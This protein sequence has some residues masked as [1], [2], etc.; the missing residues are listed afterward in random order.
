MKNYNNNKNTGTPVVGEVYEGQVVKVLDF[1]AFVNFGFAQDG[2]VHVSEVSSHRVEDIH[3][4]LSPGAVVQVRFIGLDQRGRAK[5][6]MRQA[7]GSDKGESREGGRSASRSTYSG[8]QPTVG[9]VYSGKIAK[10][11][12]FGVF[13]NFG[14]GKDGMVHISEISPNRVD[15]IHQVLSINDEVRVRF[16]GFDEQGRIKLSIKQA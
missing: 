4:V 13:V 14:F 12:D 1:G 10:V 15:N 3:K 8:P 6:S 9:E 7:S 11:V 5:L 2:M 16:I